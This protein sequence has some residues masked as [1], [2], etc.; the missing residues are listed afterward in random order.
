MSGRR[1]ANVVGLG[2]IGGSIGMALRD[3]GWTVTGYDRV[4]G[5]QFERPGGVGGVAVVAGHGPTLIP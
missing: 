5:A 1:R 2:L 4:D 3:Q